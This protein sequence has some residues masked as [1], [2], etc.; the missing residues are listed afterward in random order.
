MYMHLDSL[1]SQFSL[2]KQCPLCEYGFDDRHV[3]MVDQVFGSETLHITCPGCESHFVMMLA[4][5]DAGVG[6]IGMMS[7]LDFDDMVR[8]SQREPMSDDDLLSFYQQLDQVHHHVAKKIKNILNQNKSLLRDFVI[9]FLWIQNRR[10][11][12]FIFWRDSY[13]SQ[14]F[15]C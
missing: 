3:R 4:I 13:L 10:H 2:M 1:K 15:C 7:D 11:G 8:V 5:S 12:L 6:L 9:Y 14:V